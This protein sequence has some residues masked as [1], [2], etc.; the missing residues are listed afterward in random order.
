MKTTRRNIRNLIIFRKTLVFP[1][2]N[3]MVL[4]D[5]SSNNLIIKL[6]LGVFFFSSYNYSEQL[7]S[8][9]IQY[10]TSNEIALERTFSL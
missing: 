8:T 9:V 10:Y 1:N 5:S 2:G 6:L 7:I 3:G 4:V